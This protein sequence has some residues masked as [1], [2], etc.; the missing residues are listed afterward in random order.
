MMLSLS[1][2][3]IKAN[4][5]HVASDSLYKVP[6]GE[7]SLLM[8][9]K[10]TYLKNVSEA[11][12]WG[13]NWF[14]EAKGGASAFF[15]SPIGCGDVFDRTMPVLQVGVGKW[16]TPAIGGRVEFQGLQFKNAN[17]QKMHYQFIHAD[18]LWNVTGNFLQDYRGISR[19]DVI[20]FVGVGMV[21]NLDWSGVCKCP[22]SISGSHPFAFSYGVQVRYHVYERLHIL[23]EVSG[24]S[25]L[26]NFDAVNT[27]ARFGDNMM[28][29]S[30]GLS[31][32]I[33][34]QGWK[35]VIDARPY[36]QQNNYLIDELATLR[37]KVKNCDSEKASLA[38]KWDN[39]NN[40][41]GLNSLRYRMSISGSDDDNDNES[42]NGHAVDNSSENQIAIGVPVYFYFKLNT[43][44]LVDESQ[45][46][47]LDEIAKLAKADNLTINISGAADS[48][49]GTEQ[50]N[51]ELSKAR[52][53][54]IAQELI[55]RG[56]SK[57]QIKAVSRGGINEY[58]PV[59]ANRNTCVIIIQ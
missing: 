26:K 45:L 32:T 27:S 28:N 17:L 2:L 33:G 25:T 51:R 3:G 47:N 21:R 5:A 14:I 24:M 59:E 34:K 42:N 52:A 56:I 23:A 7:Q 31:L 30:A 53:K 12:N 57:E 41:S 43:N 36:I 58:T 49:T 40:Y 55:K 15:G 13:S 37:E 11:A 54:Y 19:W 4:E 8:P 35:R 44:H 6:V 16:F 29:V 1:V 9:L 39:K 10:P 18:F 38:S 22:G 50:I 48:A 46:S 20:P